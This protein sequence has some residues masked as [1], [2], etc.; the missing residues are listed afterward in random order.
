MSERVLAVPR[1][2]IERFLRQGFLSSDSAEL[3]E[4]LGESSV[5]LDRQAA[6]EDPSHKQ[7]IPYI[8]VTHKGRFLL[9]RRT[10]KQGESRLH[11]KLSLG[12][13]GHINDIDGRLDTGTNVILAAMVRELNEEVFIPALRQ[14]RVV[15]YINDDSSA[16]GRVHLGVAFIV[17]TSNER[18]EVNEPDLIKAKWCDASE[19]EELYPNLETWSQLLWVDC[20]KS[21]PESPRGEAATA[22]RTQAVA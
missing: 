6:E 20:I 3:M 12:F 8:V 22:Q 1:P 15:G 9:Y 17:E 5:F 7:V 10:N 16:V 14:L 19:I 2:S 11:D 13:G 21:K 18:F 4:V